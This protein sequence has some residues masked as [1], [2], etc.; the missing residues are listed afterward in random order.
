[1]RILKID[2]N[3]KIPTNAQFVGCIGYFDGMHLGHQ[4][5]IRQAI[6]GAKENQCES[7]F[8]TFDPDPWVTIHGTTEL[9]HITTLRQK[10]DRAIQFGIQNIFILNFTKE[11][12]QL[13]PE[14]FVKK[15]L[16]NC[17]LKMLVCGFDFR[18]GYQGKGDVNTIQTQSYFPV[19]IVDS[20]N[21]EQGK[22]SST[23]ITQLIQLG[24]M[25]K[26][27]SLLGNYFEMEGTVIYGKQ[28]GHNLGFPTANLDVPDEY[29]KPKAGVYAGYAKI[30]GKK[31]RAMINLGHN[32]TMNYSKSLSLEI[33]ILD[34]DQDIYGQSMSVQFVS[35][36]REEKTFQNVNNL[37]LQL[38]Q[39]RHKVRT[40]LEL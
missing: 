37:I 36:F 31:Y 24:N 2:E 40:M 28:K 21:D 34:F 35:Y 19:R 16:L 20:I 26:V 10:I 11:M 12:S 3:T 29:V 1:M 4:E 8:I 9:N 7:A 15:V 38:E 6:L 33:H 14:D 23:R 30:A 39:D 18:Y 13:S 27:T 5:L 32:P 17:N 22:I 25:E